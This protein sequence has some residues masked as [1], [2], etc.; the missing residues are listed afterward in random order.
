[1]NL[2]NVKWRHVVGSKW[3]DFAIPELFEDLQVAQV[4]IA[5]RVSSDEVP[6][7]YRIVEEQALVANELRAI[8]QM[9]MAIAEPAMFE[10]YFKTISMIEEPSSALLSALAKLKLLRR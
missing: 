3:H 10:E 5:G 1:M 4:F 7:E 9:L 8:R 6:L 2:Y